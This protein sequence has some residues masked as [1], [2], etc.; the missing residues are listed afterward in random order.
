MNSVLASQ[1][2]AAALSGVTKNYGS[3]RALDGMVVS[4]RSG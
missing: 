2:E 4:I 1:E 3:Q